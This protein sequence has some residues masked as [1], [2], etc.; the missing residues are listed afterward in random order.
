VSDLLSVVK[1]HTQDA[2]LYPVL[3]A[4]QQ[5]RQDDKSRTVFMTDALVRLFSNQHV[6]LVMG[7]NIGLT[8]LNYLPNAKKAFAHNAMGKSHAAV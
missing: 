3:R 5:K 6:P 1:T 4:Y 8:G 2:G 7:R